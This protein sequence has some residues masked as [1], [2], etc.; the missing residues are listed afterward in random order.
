MYRYVWKVSHHIDIKTVSWIHLTLYG[1]VQKKTWRN[2]TKHL[3]EN[4]KNTYQ[5]KDLPQSEN[6]WWPSKLDIGRVKRWGQHQNY[7]PM[8]TSWE[9]QNTWW[10]FFAE[11][12]IWYN[13]FGMIMTNSLVRCQK[14]KSIKSNNYCANACMIQCFMLVIDEVFVMSKNDYWLIHLSP[15]FLIHIHIHCQG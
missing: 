6:Q 15:I 9:L 8:H 14:H 13:R 2:L 3:V 12:S 4:K 11:G 7:L 5:V 10:Q 1:L